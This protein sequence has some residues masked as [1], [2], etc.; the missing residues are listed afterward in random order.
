V[1]WLNDIIDH[2]RLLQRNLP[3]ADVIRIIRSPYR[4]L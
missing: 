3:I 2:S 1:K 4:R